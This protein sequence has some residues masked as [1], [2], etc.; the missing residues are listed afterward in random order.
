M[1]YQREYVFNEF[2]SMVFRVFDE[3]IIR[4][5]KLNADASDRKLFRIFTDNRSVI[6]VKN[7]HIKENLAFI[8]FS[9]RL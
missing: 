6:G 8:N 3:N 5:E 9:E 7:K 1:N 2:Q 4:I